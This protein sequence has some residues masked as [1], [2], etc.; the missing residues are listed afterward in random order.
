MRLRMTETLRQWR[1]KFG[2]DSNAPQDIE[3]VFGSAAA[4]PKPARAESIRSIQSTSSSI[5][6]GLEKLR[7]THGEASDSSP[8][9][10]APLPLHGLARGTRNE[11][12]AIDSR[13]NRRG[14]V[15]LEPSSKPFVPQINEP[16]Q[17][18][19]FDEYCLV[20]TREFDAMNVLQ[21]TTLKIQSPYVIKALRDVV[22]YYPDNP[23][24]VSDVITVGDPPALIYHYRN[25]LQAYAK[26]S[27]I[28]ENTKLHISYVMAY[29]QVQI[30]ADMASLDKHLAK[31]LIKFDWLWMIFRP[32][33]L[34][35][36]P[37]SEELYFFKK[38]EY[39][40]G[41]GYTLYCYNNSYDGTGVGRNNCTLF[42][43][44]FSEPR[45]LFEL[46]IIPLKL[47]P[48]PEGVK[49]RLALR[50]KRFLALRGV[51]SQQHSTAGRVVIDCKTHKER[52]TASDP[53]AVSQGALEYNQ[54]KCCCAVCK[55]L[56]PETPADYNHELRELP[57]DDLILCRSTVNGFSLAQHRW[58]SLAIDNLSD[59]DWK[60][61]AMDSLVVDEKQKQ[62]ITTL[63]TSRIFLDAPAG[64]V[65][66]W[67]GK[68][69]VVLLHGE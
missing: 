14:D 24:D 27:G 50:G 10:P 16:V 11:C 30:G 18:T 17:L 41:T 9:A 68:G 49:Q 65:L 62:V 22:R 47:F 58:M 37:K 15:V 54:C 63:A 26:R 31:N 7:E 46:P 2:M 25:E 33:D 8:P 40:E 48:D 29:L 3:E 13:I 53:A 12:K 38:A 6:P 67:K 35:Y 20:V 39:T 4:P 1:Q 52:N 42:I 34:V 44:C 36:S 66:D 64:D 57:F 51:H 61:N 56:T 59:V 5:P 43:P 45:E 19:L 32:G 55:K 69:L 21:S 28:D 23:V 60:L